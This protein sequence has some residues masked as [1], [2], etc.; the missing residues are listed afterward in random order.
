[1]KVAR[2]I[3]CTRSRSIGVEVV[4]E[5]AVAPTVIA[6]ERPALQVVG[7]TA[8]PSPGMRIFPRAAAA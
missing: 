5:I 4:S 8:S 3:S 2:N 6:S 7:D 1:M